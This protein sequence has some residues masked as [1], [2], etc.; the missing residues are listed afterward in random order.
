MKNTS[1]NSLA[2]N[3]HSITSSAFL[4]FL[5]IF[6]LLFLRFNAWF[7]SSNSIIASCLVG[8]STGT[9]SP[10]A[11]MALIKIAFIILLVYFVSREPGV[12][13]IHMTVIQSSF[14]FL[15]VKC[16]GIELVYPNELDFLPA[17]FS[18]YSIAPQING[19]ELGRVFLEAVKLQCL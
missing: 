1:N 11:N 2:Q 16:S 13:P 6:F 12:A 4:L 3:K 10:A 15:R 19:H 14:N 5:P 18:M 17:A 8:H 9:G 7:D